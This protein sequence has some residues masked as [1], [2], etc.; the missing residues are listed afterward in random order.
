MKSRVMRIHISVARNI[1]K[2]MKKF[3]VSSTVAS[4]MLFYGSGV[5]QVFRK[6]RK[7]PLQEF[8]SKELHDYEI[9]ITSISRNN[10]KD[11]VLQ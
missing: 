4:E 11:K 5:G 9:K 8:L 7:M 3:N 6:I 2:T 10:G 1:E